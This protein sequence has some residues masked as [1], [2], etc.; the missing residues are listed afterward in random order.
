M[1]SEAKH[2]K[3]FATMTLPASVAQWAARWPAE[4]RIAGSV[5]AE[6]ASNIREANI[7]YTCRLPR[8]TLIRGR[9]VSKFRSKQPSGGRNFKKSCPMASIFSVVAL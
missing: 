1:T 8:E 9:R 4:L 3:L 5:S 7:S 2:S 6:D